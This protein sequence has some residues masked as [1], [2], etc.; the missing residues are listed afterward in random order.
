M[1]IQ[2]ILEELSTNPSYK[3]KLSFF[4]RVYCSRNL[5][6]QKKSGS[7]QHPD[8]GAI[9]TI[10]GERVKSKA[11]KIFADMLLESNIKY[12]YEKKYP[13]PTADSAHRQYCPDFFLPQINV[14]VEVWALRD[15]EE[16]TCLVLK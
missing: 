11:E 6:N 14:W 8:D 5:Y 15:G 12:F 4:K 3:N 1:V 10:L 2:S 16:E 9:Y 13:L 7:A